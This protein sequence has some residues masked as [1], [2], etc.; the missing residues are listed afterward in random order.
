MV[1]TKERDRKKRTI[2]DKIKKNSDKKKKIYG[3]LGGLIALIMIFSG[4][5]VAVSNSSSAPEYAVEEFEYN[6]YDFYEHVDGHYVL[7]YPYSGQRIPISFYID[8]READE[9]DVTDNVRYLKSA[10]KVYLAFNPNEGNLRELSAAAVEFGRVLPFAN[11]N[12]D[13]SSKVV[14]SFTE[15]TDPITEEIPVMSC[16]DATLLQPVVVFEMRD[17]LEKPRIYNKE[18]CIH[19]EANNYTSLMLAS[20]RLGY[21]MLGVIPFEDFWGEEV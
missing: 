5:V 4:L 20:D 1:N 14:M 16:E 3:M 9:F 2:V 19:V 17:S 15:D 12:L 8:P 11:S 6:G 10:N 18:N 7:L 13:D 21:G